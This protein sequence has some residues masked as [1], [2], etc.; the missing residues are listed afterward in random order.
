M[1]N[2]NKPHVIGGVPTF[3][4]GGVR[5]HRLNNL[6]EVKKIKD[7]PAYNPNPTISRVNGN[8]APSDTILIWINTYN[9]VDDLKLLLKDIVS[10]KS[11][12]KLKVYI[13]DDASSDEYINMLHKFSGQ[14][15]IVYHKMSFNHG[16][17]QYW[18][19]C[20]YALDKI[21][22]EHNQF[23]YFIKLD[24]DCRLVDNFFNKCINIWN[25]IDDPQKICL[26]FRLDSRE[27]KPVWTGILP[28]LIHF[29]KVPVYLSQW[30]DMDFFC[31]A[32]ML[33]SLE[34]KIKPQL[35][36]RWVKDLAASSGVGRDISVR[37]VRLKYHLYLTKE[38]LVI[39]NHHDS[40][41]NPEERGV[42]PLVTK[43]NNNPLY[44]TL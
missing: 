10:N 38:S 37:L 9:R 27:G 40:K 7:F 29:G 41:M 22:L 35:P 2:K 11:K 12:F 17:T 36:L 5:N 1:L 33:R 43:I 19:L 8:N 3:H 23:K 24:D 30:V 32:A 34:F 18:R 25:T 15:D 14:L 13:V 28:R 20:N 26:N 31:E 6:E 42:N 44:G 21:K 4:H 39:H 16:K